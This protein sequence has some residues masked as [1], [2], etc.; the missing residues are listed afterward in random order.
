MKFWTKLLPVF[1]VLFASAPAFAGGTSLEVEPY[2]GYGFLGSVG[3]K[4]QYTASQQDTYTTLGLGLRANVKFLDMFFAGPDFSYQ[5]GL[6]LTSPTATGMKLDKTN[7]G[8]LMTLGLVAGVQLPMSL[9]FWVGYN[10]MDQTSSTVSAT[11]DATAKATYGD[12][13]KTFKGSSFKIGAGYKLMSYLS[14]NAE[15]YF[16]SYS[17][18]DLKM[19]GAA[20]SLGYTDKAITDTSGNI[21][22]MTVSA[23]LD[24]LSF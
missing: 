17:K 14:I 8:S 13:T 6:S 2:L 1:A 9:R 16:Q 21:L 11:S 3:A 18:A 19:T 24:V 23:P 4:D 12:L 10:F 15:Y 20:S 7:S 22:V 5:P